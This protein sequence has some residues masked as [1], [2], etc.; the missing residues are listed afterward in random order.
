MIR[1]EFKKIFLEN[2]FTKLFHVLLQQLIKFRTKS[3]FFGE[4]IVGLS[5]RNSK[6]NN[7][8]RN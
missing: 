3:E 7:Y 1:D 5:L 2:Q 4:K 8:L 6:A